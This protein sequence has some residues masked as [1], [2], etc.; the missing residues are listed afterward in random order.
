MQAGGVG[1]SGQ[2]IYGVAIQEFFRITIVHAPPD[3][4]G[5]MF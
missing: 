2:T 5:P 1:L 4:D 3:H